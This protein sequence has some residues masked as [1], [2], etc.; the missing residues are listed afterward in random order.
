MPVDPAVVVF[1]PRLDGG[2]H[3]RMH[4]DDSDDQPPRMRGQMNR[5]MMQMMADTT[6]ETE[7]IEGEMRLRIVPDDPEE[8]DALYEHI[9]A[10]EERMQQR[11]GCPMMETM[12]GGMA[13]NPEE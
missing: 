8:V 4:G 13:E 2:M 6:A 5:E 11:Q 10:R 3:E 9:Q 12:G 7:E 1:G